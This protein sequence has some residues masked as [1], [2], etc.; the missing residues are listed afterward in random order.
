MWLGLQLLMRLSWS[1]G[2]LNGTSMSKDFKEMLWQGRLKLSGKR[3]GNFSY[4]CSR[5]AGHTKSFQPEAKA[6]TRVQHLCG[7][8]RSELNGLEPSMSQADG[9]SKP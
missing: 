8:Q 3:A 6:R 1:S 2:L 4:A 5:V 7:W 9:S